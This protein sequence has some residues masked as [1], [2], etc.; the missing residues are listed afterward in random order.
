MLDWV[1]RRRAR[2]GR[3][4]R[5]SASCARATAWPR[6]SPTA[7]S[8]RRADRG[9]GHRRRGPRRARPRRG[10]RRHRG[11]PLGRPPARLG[12]A[13]DRACSQAHARGRRRGHAPHHRQARPDRL[14]PHRARR[15]RR[16]SSGSS[17]PSTPSGVARG[18]ARDPRDQ[19]RH[20]RLRRP[21]AVSTRS[22]RC[23]EERRRA[24]PDRR[25]PD[26]RARD[27]Q[28]VAAHRTD[29]VLG[30]HGRERPRGPD[31]A[32]SAARSA[33]ILEAHAQAGVTFLAP[34]TDRVDAGVE[35]GEDTV[36]RPGVDAARARR[37]IG[38]GCTIGPH[39]TLIDAELGRRRDGARTPTSSSR[40]WATAPPI[41]PFAYL[42]PG[43]DVGA[44]ARR[45]APSSRSR[46]PTIGAGAKVPHLS[47]IGDADV[48]EGSNIA[49]RQHHRQL[50]RRRQAPHEDR[51]EREDRRRHVVR[52][53]RDVGDGA[54]TGAGSVITE[55]VPTGALGIARPKQKN[56]EGYAERDGEG[57]ADEQRLETETRPAP[58]RRVH[59]GRLRQAADGRRRPREPG[60]RRAR[61]PSGSA[62]SSPTPASRP[63]P[64]ARS[65]AATRSRSAAPTS[66]S[67][68]R[69]A[70][71]SARASP[72]T[73]RSWSCWS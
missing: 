37:A 23:G 20:L 10:R 53:P 25:L 40:A 70:A 27:G 38:A 71:P 66:S 59:P 11:G 7:S 34:E 21:D 4:S 5:S 64:T 39:T 43:A 32:S 33:R 46:T 72:S 9:R 18:G 47:Y 17:R 3:R 8:V 30:A 56:V 51:K 57:P 52:R 16:A 26:L 49:R 62:S 13:P 6:A 14:R 35:I 55:D 67:S 45:S 28:T 41:G 19:P 36:D 2:G 54:Y 29:D 12:R 1:D 58:A 63:S 31:G 48:G 42:R 24:L 61:S 68:S 69:S 50:R 73:T 15:R 65:T 44:R 60:A 22:T